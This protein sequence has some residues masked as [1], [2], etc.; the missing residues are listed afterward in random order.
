MQIECFKDILEKDYKMMANIVLPVTLKGLKQLKLK[1]LAKYL[2]YYVDH[3]L[4]QFVSK[5]N[6]KITE[7][8]INKN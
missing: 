7:V 4:K 1:A 3:R 2:R 8:K 6:P 5:I